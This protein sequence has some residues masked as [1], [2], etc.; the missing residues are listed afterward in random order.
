[1]INMIKPLLATTFLFSLLFIFPAFAYLP[2]DINTTTTL[3]N[4]LAKLDCWNSTGT[5]YCYVFTTVPAGTSRIYRYNETLGNESYCT[6]GGTAIADGGYSAFLIDN[7]TM[8]VFSSTNSMDYDLSTI[9]TGTCANSST[10][11]GDGTGVGYQST[12]GNIY[13]AVTDW[14]Y[15]PYLGIVNMSYS[16]MMTNFMSSTVA[17]TAMLPNKTD[18]STVYVGQLKYG[19]TDDL[20]FLV[21]YVNGVNTSLI[22]SMDNLYGFAD[23]NQIR[24]S[25]VKI[26]AATTWLYLLD[27]YARI[28]RMNFTR[29]ENTGLGTSITATTPINNQT[30]SA[31]MS[32]TVQLTVELTTYNNGTIS[33]YN[34]GVF[35]GNTSIT[36]NYSSTVAYSSPVLADGQHYWDAR[37]YDIY[38]SNWTTGNQTYFKEATS[39]ITT[40][41]QSLANALGVDLDYGKMMLALLISAAL[42]GALA[43][44]VKWQLFLPSMVVCSFFFAVAG[45]FPAWFT[46]VFIVVG[47]VLFAKYSGLV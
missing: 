36:A 31:V 41:G 5:I 25:L 7:D 37:F 21:K 32:E 27:D 1:M 33:W 6:L 18:N 28:Y 44:Y 42:S 10:Y 17:R 3:P 20:G 47:G 11:L 34:D 30:I 22:N 35:I 13:D 29:V 23:T 38:G 4:S 46:L 16:T 8:R 9:L 15:H 39:A 45:F 14:I 24:I 43:Y 2:I 26:D 19:Y 12:N 40:V